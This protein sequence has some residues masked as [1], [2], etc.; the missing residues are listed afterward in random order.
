MNK[1]DI[2][3]DSTQ[4]SDFYSTYVVYY[5]GY[6]AEIT[7]SDGTTQELELEKSEQGTIIVHTNGLVGNVNLRYKGTITQNLSLAISV[8]GV[9]GTTITPIVIHYYRK[10]KLSKLQSN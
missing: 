2:N 6:V 5:K 1:I 3:F 7:L 4:D 8:L 9:L 10:K